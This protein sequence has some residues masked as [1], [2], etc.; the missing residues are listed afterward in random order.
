MKTNTKKIVFLT[1]LLG[2]LGIKAIQAQSI[3]ENPQ[4]LIKWI[5]IET[6]E[7]LNAKQPKPIL[8]DFYTDWCV[9]CKKMNMTTFSN[10]SIANYINTYFYP[11]H[12]N[13]ETHDT[14][15][16][17]GQK[18]IN[19]GKEE[20]SAHELAVKLLEGKLSYP[21]LVFY[22]NNFEFKLIA[23]GFQNEKVIEPVLIYTV[24]H[25]FNTT[26]IND[27]TKAF[28]KA[29]YP[30][31]TLNK[32]DTLQW[33][34][35]FNDLPSGDSLPKKQLLFVT[36]DW[37]YSCKTMLNTTLQHSNLTSVLRK[38][39][40]C[41]QMTAYSH[42]SVLYKG[43]TFTNNSTTLTFHSF[44]LELTGGQIALPAIL[45]FDEKK[46]YINVLNQ[47]STPENLQDVVEYIYKNIYKTKSWENYM[48]EKH[49]IKK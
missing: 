8:I 48:K 43:K 14:I 25:V 37:C 2:W 15:T 33:L 16:F 26:S 6:A 27:F 34:H 35:S 39:F 9:W 5:D 47:F 30:D 7:A 22:N 41:I 49:P 29:F 17:Q 20:R 1:F 31:S 3:T 46:N 10:P 21:T 11:V 32:A 44:F 38:N 19:K 28:H 12:F 42:D 4:G 18:Y 45:F 40:N 24:E 36:A 13:A 23:P